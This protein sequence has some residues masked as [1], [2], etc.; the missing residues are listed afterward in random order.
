MTGIIASLPPLVEQPPGS[1]SSDP[2]GLPGVV[3]TAA[4]PTLPQTWTGLQTFNPGSVRFAGSTSGYTYLD[5]TAIASGTVLLPAI[6]GSD[7][8]LTNNNIATVTNKAIDGLLNTITNVP[9]GA[10]D[11]DLQAI[12]ALT[13]TGF[14]ARTAADTWALRTVTGP[15]AGITVTNGSGAAGNPTLALA[16]DLAA[17]EALA[18]TGIARRTGTD[19]WSVGTAVNLASEVTGNLPVG[20]LN[21]GTG[22]SATSFWRGDGAWVTPAGAGTVTSVTI[23]GLAITSSGTA[24][25]RFGYANAT[26]AVSAAASALTI[27]LKDNAGSNPSAT[28]PST[29]WFRDVTGTVGAWT[30]LSATG[31]MSLVVSSGSTLGVTTSTAFRLWVVMFNDGGTLRLGVINCALANPTDINIYPLNSTVPAS[32]LA[33]GGAGAADSPGVFYTGTAVTSKPFVILGYVEWSASGLTAGTWTTTNQNFIQSFGPGV[34]LPGEV[35][36]VAAFNNATSFSTTLSTYQTTNLAKAIA[37]TSAANFVRFQYSGILYNRSTSSAV[38]VFSAMHRGST[39][40]GMVAQVWGQTNQAETVVGG[41]YYDNPNTTASTTYAAKI[42]N[43]DA[44]TNMSFPATSEV[45][46]L[47]LEE[48]MT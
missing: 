13:G 23:D 4:I 9:T 5:A 29:F 7:T 19:T 31:A 18:S 40:V 25:P 33:E 20:N 17:L 16:N 38:S 46:V 48:I 3:Y 35:V 34:R 42:R 6:T 12:A 24:P 32:S 30:A 21:G 11:P 28:S 41:T 37:P 39:L 22:A 47:T 8:L 14:S 1:N 2:A 43:N 36:Q 26:I 10:L 45:C 15:A 44:T 27:A